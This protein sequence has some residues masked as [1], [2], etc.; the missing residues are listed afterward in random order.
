MKMIITVCFIFIALVAFSGCRFY[1][2]MVLENPEFPDAML[3]TKLKLKI[4]KK[5][6]VGDVI[7]HPRISHTDGSQTAAELF[8]VCFSETNSSI[9][10]IESVV[11]FIDDVELDYGDQITR[12]SMSIWESYSTDKSFYVSS[13][14]GKAL[15]CSK[16][17]ITK[18]KVD[19]SLLISVK[20]ADGKITEKQIDT[21]FVP[22]KRSYLE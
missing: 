19:V 14:S 18:A 8:V 12:E 20:G 4:L 15:D 22:K 13:I 9:V 7:V 1:A 5:Y 21:Y 11:V 2:W 10:A 17:K 16:E 3:P 6:T